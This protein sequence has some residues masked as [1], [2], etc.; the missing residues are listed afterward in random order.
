VRCDPR[1]WF[2]LA[3]R[4]TWRLLLAAIALGFIG[5]TALVDAVAQPANSHLQAVF[6]W[7]MLIAVG[8][9]ARPSR[10]LPIHDR[11]TDWIVA[12][13][14]ML[15]TVIVYV[16]VQ[17]RLGATA[18]LWWLEI[19]VLVAIGAGLST[20]LF[21]TRPT[22][23]YWGAWAFAALAGW[24]LLFRLMSAPLTAGWPTGPSWLAVSGALAA[25]LAVAGS[26]RR[27]LPVSLITLMLTW[28]VLGA[29]ADTPT[30]SVVAVTAATY[31]VA[32]PAIVRSAASVRKSWSTTLVVERS[33]PAEV[34]TAFA[35]LLAAFGL[36]SMPSPTSVSIPAAPS[37]MAD[38][39][40][41]EGWT[42]LATTEIGAVEA[43]Y[44]AGSTWTRTYLEATDVITDGIDELGR[45]RRVVVDDVRTP[46]IGSLSSTPISS[47]YDLTRWDRSNQDTMPIMAS[48]NA[49]LFAA[50]EVDPVGVSLGAT[51]VGVDVAL[52]AS[53]GRRIVLIAVD[54]HR[55]T[56]PF[57][58]AARTL[59][60]DVR[61]TIGRILRGDD[62]AAVDVAIAKDRDLLAHLAIQLLAGRPPSPG[63]LPSA[64]SVRASSAPWFADQAPASRSTSVVRISTPIER[65]R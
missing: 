21:G 32:L 58:V 33:R 54:D 28:L 13:G 14:G 5:G 38:I 42:V 3:Q 34:V 44:G 61:A 29:R 60:D 19:P 18:S 35:A 15:L 9:A 7:T 11:Q 1:E 23:R 46:T 56:A 40:D 45:A 41:P 48:V 64:P 43:I 27:W 16:S 26:W 36:L 25:G 20:L 31:V 55:I 17:P 39:I 62:A 37:D 52:P 51:F 6:A 49:T 2:A 22:S 59:A 63:I 24:P 57:P 30:A 50:V 8:A 4:A 53:G 10:Q 65:R 47:Q 12:S